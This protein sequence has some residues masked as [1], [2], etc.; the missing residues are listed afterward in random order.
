MPGTPLDPD[1]D[2]VG[3]TQARTNPHDRKTDGIAPGP[4]AVALADRTGLPG[5]VGV[6]VHRIN[7]SYPL[8]QPDG[9]WHGEALARHARFER[10]RLN[11][12]NT[13]R[14]RRG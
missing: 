7:Q 2:P 5:L 10:L 9:A 12:R 13:L 3:N 1:R 6:G 11:L 8:R 14:P 4:A